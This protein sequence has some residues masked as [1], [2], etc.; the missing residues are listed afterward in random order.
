MP[1]ATLTL[2][3]FGIH[4]PPALV[5][6]WEGEII[7][8]EKSR[9]AWKEDEIE[10]WAEQTVGSLRR[11]PIGAGEQEADLEPLISQLEH[12]EHE[13]AQMFRDATRRV[14]E[15]NRALV[16][17]ARQSGTEPYRE[18]LS[19]RSTMAKYR[20]AAATVLPVARDARLAL[21][22]AQADREDA[23]KPLPVFDD[24]DELEAFTLRYLGRT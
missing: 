6:E 11:L 10:R 22:S 1:A 8:A 24:P 21:I 14:G 15:M 2:D 18:A 13:Y 17:L 23:G 4:S 7:Q 3:D 16:R 9:S 12:V 5:M 20:D 19:L